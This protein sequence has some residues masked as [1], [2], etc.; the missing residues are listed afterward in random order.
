MHQPD[1]AEHAQ[2]R[3]VV[4]KRLGDQSTEPGGLGDQGQILQQHG[5]DAFVVVGVGDGER[6]LGI[7][8]SRRGVIL[9]DTDDRAGRL[10]DEG[11][12]EVSVVH[13]GS[14]A[15]RRRG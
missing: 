9:A 11:D 5:R 6:D 12:V 2:H 15:T 4:G 3:G 13:R 10:G 14:L 1:G 7:F 8:G